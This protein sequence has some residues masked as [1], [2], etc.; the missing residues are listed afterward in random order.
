LAQGFVLVK[1]RACHIFMLQD[2]AEAWTQPDFT[3]SVEAN[4]GPSDVGV[5]DVV[6][7]KVVECLENLRRQVLQNRFW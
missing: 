6:L 3:S 4:L 2:V 5:S 1:R 7:M